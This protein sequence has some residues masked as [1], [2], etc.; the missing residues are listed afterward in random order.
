MGDR[1]IVCYDYLDNHIDCLFLIVRFAGVV[2][3]G[4]IVLEINYL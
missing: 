3:T 4:P 2:L 1:F